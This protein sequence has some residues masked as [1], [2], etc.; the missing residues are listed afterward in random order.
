MRPD[1]TAISSLLSSAGVDAEVEGTTL[2]TVFR[3]ALVDALAALIVLR[4]G[5]HDFRMLADMLGTDTGDGIEITY[6]LRSFSRDEEVYVK[7][8]L[9]YDGE[10][11]SVW[12]AFPSALMPEREIAELLGLTLA[13]HPNPRRLFTTDGIDPLLRKRVPIRTLEEVRDR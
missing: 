10:L 11:P 13:G 3:V 8:S 7:T 1:P 6:H 5:G 12:T 9:A 2:G 4:E